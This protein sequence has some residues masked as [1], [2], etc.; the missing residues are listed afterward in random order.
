MKRA[1]ER[2][3]PQPMQS[4]NQ[5]FDETKFNFNKVKEDEILFSLEN[6]DRNTTS[7]DKVIINVSKPGAWTL[8]YSCYSEAPYNGKKS[9]QE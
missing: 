8:F 4:V 3:A 5:P 1:T 6:S 7:N 9:E 2:R